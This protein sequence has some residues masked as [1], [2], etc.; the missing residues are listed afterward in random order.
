MSTRYSSAGSRRRGVLSIFAFLHRPSLHHDLILLDIILGDRLRVHPAARDR[1]VRARHLHYMQAGRKAKWREG[2][3]I[4]RQ[5]DRHVDSGR[6]ASKEEGQLC[7]TGD[8]PKMRIPH[9]LQVVGDPRRGANRRMFQRGGSHLVSC[10]RNLSLPHRK[11]SR[12]SLHLGGPPLN[13][14]FSEDMP[15]SSSLRAPSRIWR[16]V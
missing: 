8:L 9:H 16:G 1:W 7:Q 14:R 11:P 15:C 13:R 12:S 10:W 2:R 5:V 3:Q 4:R 6:W